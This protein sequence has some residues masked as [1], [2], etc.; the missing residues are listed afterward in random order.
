MKQSNYFLPN[1]LGV[2]YRKVESALRATN[3]DQSRFYKFCL[4]A[5][6]FALKK[7]CDQIAGLTYSAQDELTFNNLCT[8]NGFTLGLPWHGEGEEDG[9]LVSICP[10]PFDNTEIIKK[11]ESLINHY[12]RY[13]VLKDNYHQNQSLESDYHRACTELETLRNE[14]RLPARFKYNKTKRKDNPFF[15]GGIVVTIPDELDEVAPENILPQT[16]SDTV[17]SQEPTQTEAEN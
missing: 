5:Q 13:Q 17:T 1:F 16:S 8:A 4:A 7:Y 14:F 3:I 12:S 10:N 6:L 11:V 15:K 9:F 2:I